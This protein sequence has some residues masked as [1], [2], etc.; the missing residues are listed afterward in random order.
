MT[1]LTVLQDVTHVKNETQTGWKRDFTL[2]TE[3]EWQLPVC[4][5]SAK[6]T[7]TQEWDTRLNLPGLYVATSA[8]VEG[9]TVCSDW[10]AVPSRLFSDRA[11]SLQ[12]APTGPCSLTTGSNPTWAGLTAV[13]GWFSCYPFGLRLS[14]TGVSDNPWAYILV[15]RGH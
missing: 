1:N 3:L 9:S 12:P 13:F 15:T 5:A 6:I 4:V 8:G 11:I 2:D 7:E 14:K 10:S